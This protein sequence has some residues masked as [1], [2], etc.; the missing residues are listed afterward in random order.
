MNC[1]Q[2]IHYIAKKRNTVKKELI[3]IC[4]SNKC[5]AGITKSLKTIHIRKK[6]KNMITLLGA[7][8]VFWELLDRERIYLDRGLDFTTVCD[9]IGIA[10]HRLDSLI[11]EETGL[12]GQE[13]LTHFRGVGFSMNYD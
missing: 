12:H 6:A 1:S 5:T 9:Y 4:T 2:E 8:A 7:Y 11:Y 10:A 13:V 3:P